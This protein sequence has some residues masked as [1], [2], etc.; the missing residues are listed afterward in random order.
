MA[1]CGAFA[2]DE[3]AIGGACHQRKAGHRWRRDRRALHHTRERTLPASRQALSGRRGSA[4]PQ[5]CS[6]AVSLC[7]HHSDMNGIA[8]DFRDR[9]LLPIPENFLARWARRSTALSLPAFAPGDI[10]AWMLVAA[11]RALAFWQRDLSFLPFGMG[12]A[13]IRPVSRF[14]LWFCALASVLSVPQSSAR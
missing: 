10:H 5:E 8:Q 13:G 14:A 1:T 7:V 3:R 6:R 12:G 2:A 11:R 4:W 9:M